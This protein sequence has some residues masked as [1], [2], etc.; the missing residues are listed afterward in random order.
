MSFTAA[1]LAT[2]K[3]A[4]QADATAGP[5]A[6]SGALG[7]LAAYLNSAPTT[8]AALVTREDVTPTELFHA[9]VYAEFSALGA[10][11]L[12]MLGLAKAAARID[13]T[14]ANVAS[15]LTQIFPSTTQTYANI[16]AIAQRA[17]TRLE[18]IFAT[19]GVSQVYGQ[20]IG[21]SDLIAAGL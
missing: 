17:A 3:S 20:T 9:I 12:A 11:A 8:G 5:L 13:F 10:P 2:I 6:S 16:M 1:Q 7:Q 21:V 19:G 15:G 4:V 18:A 14:N